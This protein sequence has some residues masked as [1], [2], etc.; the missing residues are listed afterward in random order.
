MF[1]FYEYVYSGYPKISCQLGSIGI[2]ILVQLDMVGT[3]FS[4]ELYIKLLINFKGMVS[5]KCPTL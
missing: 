4:I 2:T 3:I 1:L 5:C